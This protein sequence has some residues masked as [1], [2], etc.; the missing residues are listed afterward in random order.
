MG[1]FLNVEKNGE[2]LSSKRD[3][4]DKVSFNGWEFNMREILKDDFRGGEKMEMM[5]INKVYM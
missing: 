3:R 4:I 5:F 1:L 2:V